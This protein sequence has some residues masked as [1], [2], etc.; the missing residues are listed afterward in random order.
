MIRTKRVYD[1]PSPGDGRRILIDRLWP[2]G[3]GKE[4][5]RL[6]AWRRDLAP[7]DDL[8]RWFGHDPARFAEFRRR[9]REELAVHPEAI[10]ELVEG[11]RT[12][13]ITLVFA[14]RD[15]EHCNAAV[16]RELVEERARRGP[17]RR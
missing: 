10:A 4:A 5:A 1:S 7:S 11:A 12:G 6:A 14:A 2:R 13:T 17:A 15:A 8:R 9:Y 16:L 3:V